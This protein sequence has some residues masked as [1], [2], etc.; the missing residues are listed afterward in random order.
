LKSPRVVVEPRP[1]EDAVPIVEE[2]TISG[3]L[4]RVGGSIPT[5]QIT[6]VPGYKASTIE[7]RCSKEKLRQLAGLLYNYIT[8]TVEITWLP[9]GPPEDWEIKRVELLDFRPVD[10][11]VGRAFS[12]LNEAFKNEDIPANT[13]EFVR[14]LRSDP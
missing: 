13:A 5:A 2:T 8:A 6:D 7:A 10:F 1:I 11:N 4:F 14:R 9:D 3:R 12:M